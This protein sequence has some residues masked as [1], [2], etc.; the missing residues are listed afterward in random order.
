M[1]LELQKPN[2]VYETAGQPCRFSS[3]FS[4]NIFAKW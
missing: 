4:K 1:L 3:K 2:Q